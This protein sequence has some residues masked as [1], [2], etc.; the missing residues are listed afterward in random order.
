MATFTITNVSSGEVHLGDF[1]YTMDA[2]EVLTLTNRSPSEVPGLAS[3]QAALAA[4]DITFSIA[5]T[6]DE[7]DSGLMTAPNTVG[8]DDTQEVA[9]ADLLAL[10]TSIYNEVAA[11][12]GGAPDDVTL[13]ALD[14]VPFKFRVLQAWFDVTTAVGASTCELNDE[15]AAAGTTLATFSTGAAGLVPTTSDIGAVLTPSATKGLFL[16]RSDSGVAGN[17]IVLVRRE[18]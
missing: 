2:G 11:G 4:G 7:L 10:P 12:G 6:A 17:L 18:S 13:Y 1:Y 9:A 14:A 8:G 5:Y 3:V 16:R 15:A